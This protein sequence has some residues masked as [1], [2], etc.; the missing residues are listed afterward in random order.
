MANYTKQPFTN[1]EH[2]KLLQE[3]G[4]IIENDD[5]ALKYLDSIGYYRLSGYMYHLQNKKDNSSFLKGTTFSQII[6]LYK[7]DKAL[8]VLVLEYIE[9]IE[10]CIRS[11][12]SNKYSLK[13]GFFWYLDSSL[14]ADK[15][16]FDIIKKEIDSTFK[17]PQEQFLKSFKYHY[18]DET[19]PPSNM[20]LE[21]L[22]FGKVSKL[23]KGLDNIELKIEIATEFGQASSTLSSWLVYIN[24]VRN[25]CAHHARLWNKK[26]TAD[27]PIIPNRDKYKFNGSIPSNIDFNTSF[28]CI[29]SIIDRLLKSFNPGNSFTKRLSELILSY[30]INTE[31]MGF[32]EDWKT[33]AI[34]LK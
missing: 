11:K 9:R 22:T 5:R 14:F 2:I 31:L 10:V 32:P 28:Y 13:Y 15:S 29:A 27:R 3:R 21:I 8:R 12:I 24:N 18:N 26:V 1:H 25:I 30:E 20:A 6:D 7:F 33:E 23:Y 34:W 19:F 17:D 4:L 16:T